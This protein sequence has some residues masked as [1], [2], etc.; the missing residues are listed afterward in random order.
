MFNELDRDDFPALSEAERAGWGIDEAMEDRIIGMII[1][2]ADQGFD[3]ST[4]LAEYVAGELDP[5]DTW[6]D[7]D[8]HPIWDWRAIA[9]PND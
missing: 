2:N 5:T 7:D 3:D 6:L 9:V 4:L 8:T 1:R